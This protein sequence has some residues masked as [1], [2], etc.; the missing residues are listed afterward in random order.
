MDDKQLR[1]DI[2]DAL[3]WDPSVDSANIGVA[4]NNGVAI[5]SGHISNYA[6]KLAAGRIAKRVKGVTAIADEI[7]VRFQGAATPTDEDIASHAVRMLDWDVMVPDEAIAVKV[8]KGFVT[9]TGEVDWDYQRRAAESDVRKLG[10]I[11]GVSNQITLKPKV[12]PQDVSHRIA[13][14]LK[15]DAEV[16]ASQVHVSVLDGKVRLEGRVHSWHEREAA[17][18]A[19]WAAPGVRSVE[20]N[21]VIG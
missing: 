8:S 21:V 18:R 12:S 7:E 4:V 13:A 19:V 10:G 5:L 6:Q 3:D 2:I 15:R 20:D 9:L 1:K 17:E 11:V 16:E 14:A